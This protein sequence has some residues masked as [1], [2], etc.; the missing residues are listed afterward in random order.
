M[1]QDRLILNDKAR[2]PQFLT[3]DEVSSEITVMTRYTSRLH[4]G[5]ARWRNFLSYSGN[6]RD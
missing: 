4:G 6:S 3:P 5:G 1:E 2:R